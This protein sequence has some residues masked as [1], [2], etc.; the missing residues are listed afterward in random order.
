LIEC[1]NV[2][3]ITPGTHQLLTDVAE[4][5]ANG[6]SDRD[7]AAILLHDAA[8]RDLQVDGP[9]APFGWLFAHATGVVADT[10]T[11]AG[12]GLLRYP[13]GGM[14][15]VTGI[16]LSIGAAMLVEARSTKP[17]VHAPESIFDPDTFFARLGTYTSPPASSIEDLIS[18]SVESLSIRSD[19]LR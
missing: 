3:V 2:M 4:L 15:E 18:V 1:V 5:V 17:G 10:P 8:T 16:P 6:A 7:A 19:V 13:P 9:A 11:Q 14:A 12:V